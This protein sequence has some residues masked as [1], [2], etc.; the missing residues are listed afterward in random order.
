MTVP[1]LPDADRALAEA[2][3]RFRTLVDPAA[4]HALQPP[5]PAAVYTPWV[6]T[7]LLVYQRLHQGAS[8]EAAVAELLRI[9]PTLS[10]NRRVTTG[11]LSAN[12][13]AYSRARSRLDVAVAHAVA[14]H[15][16]ATLMAA[17]PTPIAGRRAFVLDG[18][19]VTLDATP[20]L[21]AAFPPAP[22]QHGGGA[23]PVCQL[24]VA[25]EVASGCALR[26]EAGAIAGPKAHGEV[27][28][29]RGLFGR[30]PA[31]SVL[32]AD[33]N[34]GTFAFVYTAAAAG[35][36]PIV[37]LTGPRFA[38]CQRDARAVG[39]G[40][41]ELTW[42]PSA[43]ERKRHPEWP[44]DAKV[45]VRLHA[46]AV[47]P[48]L[49][50]YL[51]TTLPDAGAAVAEWYGHRQDV[52]TDIRDVKRTLS[53]THVR[54]RSV[55]MLAKELAM[56][57]VAYNLVVQVR[58]LAAQ[59]ARVAPRRL[60]FAGTRTLVQSLLLTPPAEPL[61]ATQWRQRFEQVLRGVR[62]RQVPSRP[63]RSYPRTVLPHSSKYPKQRRP[64]A[65]PITK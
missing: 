53:L 43:W 39:P 41:W 1:A 35:H 33:R 16:F 47:T 36:D 54:C 3:E 64:T 55:A 56:A 49:T 45:A 62:Q 34:F 32:L 17:W 15:V 25:H 2:L 26:P 59:Q 10:A 40:C 12:S 46:V 58:R 23:W 65:V 5:G 11:T 31:G 48:T 57:M 6:V 19:T 18:S 14:D 8:L 21:L 13:G 4:V 24:L 7:W 60:S 9:A 37:R 63:G 30:L 44:A 28:L 61:T 50:L 42:R 27:A 22:N 51:A 52:E 38:K 20:E 29:A